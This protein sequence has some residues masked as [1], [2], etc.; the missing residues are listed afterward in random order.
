MV[1][2]A[3]LMSLLIA[4]LK[5]FLLFHGFCKMHIKCKTGM[6]R[7]YCRKHVVILY[8]LQDNVDKRAAWGSTAAFGKRA[9]WADTAAF[10][11]FID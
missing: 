2:E 11:L 3:E 8:H 7:C 9:P 10:G 5:S 4:G 1:N 6:V